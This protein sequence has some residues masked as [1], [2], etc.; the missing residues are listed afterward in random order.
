MAL[1]QP[2]LCQ[3]GTLPSRLQPSAG[4]LSAPSLVES[5]CVLFLTPQRITNCTSTNNR[6]IIFQEL[7]WYILYMFTKKIRFTKCYNEQLSLQQ[8][9]CLLAVV[10]VSSTACRVVHRYHLV[11]CFVVFHLI[12]G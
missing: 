11:G 4:Y 5:V 3:M 9:L 12:P 10:L 2:G 6:K 1:L 7:Y 8:S